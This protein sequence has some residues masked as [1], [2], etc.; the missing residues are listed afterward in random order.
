MSQLLRQ[1]A[2]LALALMFVAPAALAEDQPKA[3]T[4]SHKEPAKEGAKKKEKPKTPDAPAKDP[5]K[6]AEPTKPEAP[7]AEVTKPVEAPKPPAPATHVVKKEAFKIE[8]NLSGVLEGKNATEIALRPEFW[9]Q[10][11]ITKVVDHGARVKKGDVLIQYDT[12]AL[13]EVIHDTEASRALADLEFQAAQEQ[14]SM[15]EETV[16]MDM[17]A[18]ERAKQYFDEDVKRYFEVEVPLTRRILDENLKATE[19]FLAYEREEL[20]QLE[21][22][23]KADD[24]VEETEEIILKRQRD[25]VARLE[26]SLERTR[27]MKDQAFNISMPRE[28]LQVKQNEK[29]SELRVRS[30][31]AQFPRALAQ[32]RLAVQKMT[33]D[34]EKS[35]ETLKKLKRDRA[36]MTVKAPIDG[37]VYYGQASRGNW[38]AVAGMAAMLAPNNALKP[39]MVLMTVVAPKPLIARTT[40]AEAA[41]SLAQ[42]GI[43]GQ[44]VPVGYGEVKLPAKLET[45]NLVPLAPG[46]FDATVAINTDGAGNNALVPGMNCAIKLTAYENKNALVLPANL[47]HSDGDSDDA[48]KV[49]YLLEG[50]KHRKVEVTTGKSSNNKT[51]VLT[52]I[53]EGDKVLVNK[54]N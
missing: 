19:N 13:D 35:L 40:I 30:A 5:A 18:A 42:T 16:P 11:V 2:I 47:I 24:L 20:R 29:I 9:Q 38:N 28:E 37:I 27:M 14:L 26:F 31:R 8:L 50:D 7:K 10:W 23:Y 39:G 41:L 1:C 32:Q 34:R 3:D 44:A 45:L 12:K 51:E 52:G 53:K 15:M 43:N 48:K 25:T 21:K 54:P 22:M 49:I 4:Q 33:R 36:A 6:P 17:A 46:Q